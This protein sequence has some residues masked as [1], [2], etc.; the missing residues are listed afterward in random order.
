VF[1]IQGASVRS[2]R[3]SLGLFV[4]I[5]L[6]PSSGTGDHEAKGAVVGTG[7]VVLPSITILGLYRDRGGAVVTRDVP[8]RCCVVGNP[9]RRADWHCWFTAEE[10][11]TLVT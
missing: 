5:G 6:A 9:A 11:L 1:V 2:T 10:R 3:A 7:A 8:D 4:S